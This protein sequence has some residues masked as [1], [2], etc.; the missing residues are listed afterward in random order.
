MTLGLLLDCD[1][2]LRDL[3][4]WGGKRVKILKYDEYKRFVKTFYACMLGEDPTMVQQ[5]N[6]RTFSDRISEG[7]ERIIGTLENLKSTFVRL[8]SHV[9]LWHSQGFVTRVQLVGGDSP[10][11]V[12]SRDG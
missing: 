8:E 10:R 5:M 12:F 1:E 4:V 7:K 6:N 11:S 9:K 2:E 3:Q